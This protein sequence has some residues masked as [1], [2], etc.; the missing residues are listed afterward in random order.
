MPYKIFEGDIC[1]V[2]KNIIYEN[3]TTGLAYS[4]EVSL[5]CE[6]QLKPQFGEISGASFLQPSQQAFA[7]HVPTLT[8]CPSWNIVSFSLPAFTALPLHNTAISLSLSGRECESRASNSTTFFALALH[9]S[10][11]S[12]HF[13]IPFPSL[14]FLC[15]LLLFRSCI[16]FPT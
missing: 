3:C 12:R 13:A 9:V 6:K 10:S 8:F 2:G 15:L 7:H 11:F 4:L 16:S 14:I 5:N 1:T